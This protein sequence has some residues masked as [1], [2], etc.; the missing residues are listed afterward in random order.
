MKTLII[1]LIAA[2]FFSCRTNTNSH[3]LYGTW[4]VKFADG[5]KGEVRFR[6]DGTHDYFMD[7]KLFSSGKSRFSNDTLQ[8][9]DPICEANANYYSTYKVNFLAGDSMQ[10]TAIEDSCEPRRVGLDKG[11]F[12][13]IKRPAK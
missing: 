10:L 11:M 2:S 4:K 9:Y 12:Y 13:L 8:E 6:K 7:G 1:F 5:T 3:D